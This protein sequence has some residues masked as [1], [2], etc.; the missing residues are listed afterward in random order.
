VKVSKL[1]L[2]VE[3][4][5]GGAARFPMLVAR[6]DIG[7]RLSRVQ[8]NRDVQPEALSSM[9]KDEVTPIVSIIFSDDL[10]LAYNVWQTIGGRFRR[11]WTH[12][13]DIGGS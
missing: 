7:K 10:R 13:D 9:G 12:D 8:A 2:L 3:G 4:Q 6:D 1:H 5:N 11:C